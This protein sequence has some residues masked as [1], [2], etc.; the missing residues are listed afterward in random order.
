MGVTVPPRRRPKKGRKVPR[1]RQGERRRRLLGVATHLF[2]TLGYRRTTLEDV[3]KSA[4]VTPSVLA[5][6]FDGKADLLRALLA[7]VRAATVDRWGERRAAVADPLAR[8]HAV[9]EAFFAAVR[10]LGPAF[11]FL[12]RAL[13]DEAD[14]EA[15][16]LLRGYLDDCAAFLAG[17]LRDGRRVGLVRRR[18]EPLAA[19][20]HIIQAALAA[21]LVAPLRPRREPPEA[22]ADALLHG[23]L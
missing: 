6:H 14:D 17:L 15:L 21:A 5:R 8:L 3:A 22:A 9:T 12:N 16:P 13:A 1:L 19:A 2:G 10:D 4:D 11:R 20:W 23:L 7:E 18:T